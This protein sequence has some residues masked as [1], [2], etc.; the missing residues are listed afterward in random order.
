MKWE[1]FRQVLDTQSQAGFNHATK[2]QLIDWIKNI[3]TLKQKVETR[4]IKGL[5]PLLN[6][7]AIQAKINELA[8]TLAGTSISE[9]P[10]LISI[11]NGAMPFASQLQT[12]LHELGVQF[13]FDNLK[14]S[15]YVGTESGA[16]TVNSD[17]KI[18]VAG[19]DII[20]VDDVCDTGKTLRKIKE[21]LL[22][23]GASS[24]QVVVLVDKAQARP[25]GI[26]PDISGFVVSKDA[27]ILGCGLDYEQLGRNI[28]DIGAVDP[29]TL[30]NETEKAILNHEK[31]LATSLRAI[32]NPEPQPHVAKKVRFFRAE[33]EGD[34]TPAKNQRRLETYI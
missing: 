1:T 26:K 14:A 29:E 25:E 17:L 4:I 23:Q 9:M 8:Q 6:E 13:Q 19:R 21:K 18:S 32:L 33:P 24:V 30:P 15:S 31:G 10:I 20:L 12:K 7:Q 28:P 16:L 34:S 5:K 2:E 11:L 27:F 22:Q 3:T